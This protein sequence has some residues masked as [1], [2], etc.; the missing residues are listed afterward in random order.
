MKWSAEERQGF[1]QK[2]DAVESV[3]VTFYRLLL[4]LVIAAVIAVVVL[5]V[6]WRPWGDGSQ[7]EWFYFSIAVL[8]VLGWAVG[9]LMVLDRRRKEKPAVQFRSNSDR[10]VWTWEVQIGAAEGEGRPDTRMS[11]QA[12]E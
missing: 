5:A 9:Q 1:L 3:V 2:L 8:L 4:G 7:G 10:G 6:I 11:A 12:A